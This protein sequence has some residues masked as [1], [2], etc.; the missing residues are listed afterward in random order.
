LVKCK[1]I[2]KREVGV[3]IFCEEPVYV[4]DIEQPRFM[5][6]IERPLYL[7]LWV[8]RDCYKKY[9]DDGTL[10]SFITDNLYSYLDKYN[11]ERNGK[12]KKISKPRPEEALTN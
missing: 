5:L 12:K 1:V 8:H 11:E 9:R 6:A 7:N 10:K 2:I 4:G 3:C